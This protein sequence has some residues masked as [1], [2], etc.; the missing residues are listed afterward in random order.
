MA[1]RKLTALRIEEHAVHQFRQNGRC[2]HGGSAVNFAGMC[3]KQNDVISIANF[4]KHLLRFVRV[5]RVV[6]I[7]KAAFLTIE[8][9]WKEPSKFTRGEVVQLK[10]DTR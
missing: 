4:C 8:L 2:K 6:K 1:S 3:D 9:S 10:V 7:L 5:Y